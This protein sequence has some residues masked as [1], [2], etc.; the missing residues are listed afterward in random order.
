MNKEKLF[1]IWARRNPKFEIK[2]ETTLIRKF[3]DYGV[4]ASK[5]STAK[6][7]TFGGGYELYIYAF[8]I[9]LYKDKQIELSDENKTFGYPIQ[10]WGNLSNKKHRKSYEGIRDYIFTALVAR[11]DK[12]D[13]IALEKNELTTNKAVDY[14]IETMEKYANYGFH[15]LEDILEDNPTYFYKAIGFLDLLLEATN[16]FEK[17]EKQVV[18]SLD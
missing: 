16:T 17:Q 4:G 5:L 11:A 13:I 18:E 7:K 3:T 12:F 6:G 9:G 10:F 15:F 8:F 2:F 14:L 1:D